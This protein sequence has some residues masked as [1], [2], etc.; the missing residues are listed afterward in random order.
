MID[1]QVRLIDFPAGK[2]KEAITEN[3]DGTYTIFIDAALSREKQK[4][5]FIHAMK[6][7]LNEDFSKEDVQEIEMQAHSMEAEIEFGIV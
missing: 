7:V 1:Y 6:H 5:R 3:E 2:S 4:E